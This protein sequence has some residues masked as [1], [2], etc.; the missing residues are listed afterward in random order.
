LESIDFSRSFCTWLLKEQSGYGRFTIEAVLR[1]SIEEFLLLSGVMAAN[2]YGKENLILKPTYEFA[3]V[4]G[5]SRYRVFRTHALYNEKQDTTDI[6]S[7]RFQAV[8][9]HL[10]RVSV[11]A[12]STPQQIIEATRNN[13]MLNAHMRL[14]RCELIFPVKHMNV[15]TDTKNFQVETGPIL[16]PS[17]FQNVDLNSFKQVFTV[18]NRLD[19]AE[20]AVRDVVKIDNATIRHYENIEKHTASIQLV[21]L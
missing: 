2:V 8:E 17:D 14:P 20:F 16:F 10:T 1:T 13:K 15:Q 3:A 6:I 12:L 5:K 21:A 19:E 4:F 18:F 11:S 7:D 9:R